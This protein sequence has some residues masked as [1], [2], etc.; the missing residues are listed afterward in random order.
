MPQRLRHILPAVADGD[1]LSGSCPPGLHDYHSLG[2]LLAVQHGRRRVLEQLYR[3]YRRRVDVRKVVDPQAVDYY[4]GTLSVE[5][6]SP[7]DGGGLHA[8]SP[9]RC[10]HGEPGIPALHGA[11]H[12]IVC[13]ATPVHTVRLPRTQRERAQH[14]TG[15]NCRHTAP[16]HHLISIHN[17][18]FFKQKLVSLRLR[19]MVLDHCI[20]HPCP[21]RI[22]PGPALLQFIKKH[23]CI[24][25]L[26]LIR[27]I[28]NGDYI[29]S[30]HIIGIICIGCFFVILFTINYIFIFYIV[31]APPHKYS[32][33]TYDPSGSKHIILCKKNMTIT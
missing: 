25:Y 2:S 26:R 15:G 22:A 31:F 19:N 23:R 18:L 12:I 4:Q 11:E 29:E 9:A 14:R 7:Q 6:I 21:P 5:G 30:L 33:I 17:I 28:P 8:G 16:Q 1:T 3:L 32:I 24:A 13:T 20:H 10:E 27:I